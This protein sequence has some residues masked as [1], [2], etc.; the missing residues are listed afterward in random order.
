MTPSFHESLI[1]LA[2]LPEVRPPGLLEDMHYGFDL[3]YG[4]Y[5]HSPNGGEEWR[6]LEEMAAALETRQL[7]GIL[8]V[9]EA[10][11]WEAG[12][13]LAVR[14]ALKFWPRLS[15]EAQGSF[16]GG[17]ARHLSGPR[18]VK[19][20]LEEENKLADFMTER[21]P[22]AHL[23]AQA[24]AEIAANAVRANEPGILSAVLD[25]P[26]F[27]PNAIIDRLTA[28]GPA[29][30]FAN[31]ISLHATRTL[32]VLLEC[33]VRCLQ[34]NSAERLLKLGANP[35][36]PC[37]NLERSYNEWFSLLSYAL[38]SI[39][40]S[41]K[42]ADAI[43]I[44]D[45][46]LEH[47]A[48]PQGL[49][50]EGL[51]HPL[52]L[53]LDNQRWDIADRLLDL[54]A[55]FNGGR[56]LTPKEFEKLGRLIPAGHPHFGVFD[57]DL[58]WVEEKIAPLM[59]LLKPWQVPLF[60]LGNAQGGSNS[61]FL[62]SLLSE[63]HLDK[64]KHYEVRGLPARLT[65]ALIINLVKWGHYAALLHILRHEPNLPR[66][67]FSIRRRNPSIG[68]SG[69]QAWLSQPQGNAI[70]ELPHF[71][72]GDQEALQM[73]DGSR[74][75]IFLDAVAPPNHRHGPLTGGCFWLEKHK[76][77]HR[78]RRDRVLVSHLMRH[79][80]MEKLARSDYDILEMLP[81]VKEVSGRYF[82]PG[83]SV[84]NMQ[85]GQHFPEEWKPA[86][87]AWFGQPFERTK[88][89]FHQRVLDQLATTPLLPD[90]VLSDVE[91]EPYPEEFWPYLRRL[92]DGTIGVTET[93]TRPCPDM[94]DMY[95]IWEKQV[96]PPRDFRPDPRVLAW[97]LW[98]AVPIELRPFFVWDDLFNKPSVSYKARNDYERAMIRKAANWNND[99]FIKV[100]K[101]AGL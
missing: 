11:A 1:S 95:S 60:Y 22:G 82:L 30:R 93:S 45:L 20:R 14:L 59:P 47:G 18:R 53:A 3:R 21:I 16:L 58:L 26:Q 92:E 98:P 27:E 38:H 40:H 55:C 72:P 65:P 89:K 48:N 68:T 4:G 80:R 33:A 24:S 25:H 29:N 37:W 39:W 94:Q 69:L 64:L 32:D 87:K 12:S 7:E 17:V 6:S 54:G 13:H 85:F 75:Y 28:T 43:R 97:P 10:R 99:Q 31:Q 66:L 73:P 101:D 57:E 34:P 52:K 88:E 42:T 67:M 84:R 83:I 78:R 46:L 50:C 41:E 19:G 96:K 36:L 35:D 15:N 77:D 91:L 9:L 61:T 63:E 76:A 81:L 71:D 2:S 90:P 70:N 62:N 49:P 5:Q 23:D 86:V 8:P 51:N 100:L 79:W 44:F 74:F 56:S